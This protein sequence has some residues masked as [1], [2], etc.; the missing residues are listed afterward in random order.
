MTSVCSSVIISELSTALQ[1]TMVCA[2]DPV[3]KCNPNR[4]AVYQRGECSSLEAWRQRSKAPGWK[5]DATHAAVPIT[6]CRGDTPPETRR[7]L[8]PRG[9]CTPRSGRACDQPRLGPWMKRNGTSQEKINGILLW[10]R[11]RCWLVGESLAHRSRPRRLRSSLSLSR[12]PY[13]SPAYSRPYAE[14]AR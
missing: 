11:P 10:T 5:Q 4:A 7:Q 2:A 13:A 8:Y 12:T 3:T 14:E 1:I 9:N 6:G